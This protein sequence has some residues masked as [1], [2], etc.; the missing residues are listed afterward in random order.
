ML[1]LAIFYNH[2]YF[3]RKISMVVKRTAHQGRQNNFVSIVSIG[4]FD[5]GDCSTSSS[6][7][8]V[9]FVSINRS[10]TTLENFLRCFY[11]FPVRM[12]TRQTRIVRKTRDSFQ[13]VAHSGYFSNPNPFHL[14]SKVT[15]SKDILFSFLCP[16]DSNKK[17]LRN[18]CSNLVQCRY[19]IFSM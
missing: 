9:D 16:I 13:L 5:R 11:L 15:A 2:A 7:Y 17:Y 4:T 19:K 1:L 3:E 18:L 12:K 6:M 14:I 8:S 10:S